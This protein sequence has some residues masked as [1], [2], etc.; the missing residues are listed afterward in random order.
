MSASAAP[1]LMTTNCICPPPGRA[2]RGRLYTTGASAYPGCG[3]I[4]GEIGERK[5]FSA[6][7]A[8]AKQ[9]PPPGSWS[10]GRLWAALPIDI[11]S[12]Q[13]GGC[14]K[15]G[16]HPEICGDGRLRRTAKSRAYYTEF[17]ERLPKDTVILTAGCAKYR[18][19]KL[20]LGISAVFPGCWTRDSATTPTLW[21][22]SP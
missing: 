15:A 10:R 1:I 14:G 13:G 9:C 2:T 6:I 3:H 18:Y 7:I 12:G 8:H 4:P 17:A 11:R 19:N 22:S 20:P 21:R 5:D 16:R